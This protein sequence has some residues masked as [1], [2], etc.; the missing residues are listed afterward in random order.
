MALVTG[1]S[2]GIG[3]A[4]AIELARVDYDVMITYATNSQAADEAA[5][6]IRATN[7]ATRVAIC[8]S[9]VAAASDRENLLQRTREEFGRLD[10]LVNNAGI[11]PDQRVDLLNASVESFDRLMGVN[12]KGPY[13]LT[14]AVATWRWMSTCSDQ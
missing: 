13:F 5:A 10:L 12:L 9:D 14:Q 11:A 8:R 2:R 4:I 7:E 1:A 3:R 6:A